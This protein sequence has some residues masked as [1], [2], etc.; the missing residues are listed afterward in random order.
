[1]IAF[2]ILIILFGAVFFLV[3]RCCD[4]REYGLIKFAKELLNQILMVLVLFSCLNFGFSL[5]LHAEY[6][7]KPKPQA[8]SS[9]F[10]N[11]LV[12]AVALLIMLVNWAILGTK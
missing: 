10:F 3:S 11:I 12:M 5:A 4:T 6:W 8:I 9:H 1:M 2:E 7:A